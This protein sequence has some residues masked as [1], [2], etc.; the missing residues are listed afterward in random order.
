MNLGVF[1]VLWVK[2]KSTGFD[3]L[4]FVVLSFEMGLDV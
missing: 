2:E 1:M 3:T 4:I